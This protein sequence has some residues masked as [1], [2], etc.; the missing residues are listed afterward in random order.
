MPFSLEGFAFFTEAI[1]LGVYLY[2]LGPRPAARCTSSPA[3]WSPER[4][5]SALF[6]VLANAWM[7]APAGF[8]SAASRST[9]T[10]SRHVRARR[11]RARSLHMLLAATRHGFGRRGH[12]RGAAPARAASAL[13]PRGAR[14][15]LVVA[16]P[17][18]RCC[19]R[20]P[21]DFAPRVGAASQ[22]MKLAA[23][24]GAVPHR[25][26]RALALGGWPEPGGAE[27]APRRIEI[28]RRAVVPGATPP[29]RARCGA[30]MRCRGTT[31]RR[32]RWCTS[33]SR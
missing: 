8:S 28:P 26:R 7:N 33:R 14:L 9:S 17:A 12:P 29:R 21:D 19:S 10:R 18:P 24:E 31:G 1:F 3:S 15:A 6:V 20:S 16:V 27:D 22:P 4:R 5:M 25:A 32:T 2:G 30:S 13:S 11:R 23:L